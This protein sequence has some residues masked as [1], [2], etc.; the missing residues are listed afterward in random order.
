M[1]TGQSISAS[2]PAPSNAS[3]S[4]TSMHLDTTEVIHTTPNIDRF[5]AQVDSHPCPSTVRMLRCPSSG[6][7]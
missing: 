3:T 1:I 6:A 2:M 7:E 5:M 4:F